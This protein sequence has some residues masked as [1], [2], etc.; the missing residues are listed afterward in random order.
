MEFGCGIQRLSQVL[1]PPSP[2]CC[3]P[4]LA[5]RPH[6]ICLPCDVGQIRSSF[7][8]FSS[9]PSSPSL[10]FNPPHARKIDTRSRVLRVYLRAISRGCPGQTSVS[11]NSST[12]GKHGQT[13]TATT[14]RPSSAP[15]PRPSGCSM[16]W[17]STSSSNC[18]RTS[19]TSTRLGRPGW[20]VAAHHLGKDTRGSP[21][22]SSSSATTANTATT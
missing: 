11:V 3:K 9:S 12:K 8:F 20:A 22:P 13:R 6:N 15:A 21:S 10:T 14:R 17:S 7:L 1:W 19:V 2:S 18:K 5:P 16:S 4:V